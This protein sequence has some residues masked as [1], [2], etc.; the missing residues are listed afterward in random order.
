MTPPPLSLR[1][2]KYC[3]LAKLYGQYDLSVQFWPENAIPV[4]TG[5][6]V[7][8][9]K[10]GDKTFSDQEQL[11]SKFKQYLD[12]GYIMTALSYNTRQGL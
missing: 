4:L 1:S 2:H 9:L 10:K 6:P 11:K 8:T 3:R 7:R 12:E 5:L